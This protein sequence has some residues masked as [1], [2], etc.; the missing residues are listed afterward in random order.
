MI[1]K[2]LDGKVN[3]DSSKFFTEQGS[4][5][6]Q[7]SAKE[8]EQDM[9]KELEDDDIDD[10]V[11]DAIDNPDEDSDTGSTGIGDNSNDS[12]DEDGNGK[13][14]DD[15]N[16]NNNDS[17]D[18]EGSNENDDSNGNEGNDVNKNDNSD[19]EGDEATNSDDNDA[20]ADDDGEDELQELTQN[21]L[22]KLL[23]AID[24][25]KDFTDGNI[26]KESIESG[27]ESQVEALETA[28]IT[29]K[30]VCDDAH[31]KDVIVIKNLT[32]S[33]IDNDPFDIFEKNG[34]SRETIQSGITLGTML[35]RKLQIRNEERTTQFTRLK[36]GKID[37]RLINSLGYGAEQVFS[38]LT[39][40]KFNPVKLH[41]SID[42]S[43]SMHGSKWNKT[44]IAAIAICKAASMT[45]NLDVVLDIRKTDNSDEK[46]LVIIVY[47]SRRDKFEKI[48]RVMP[49][50]CAGG[51]TPEGLCFEAI[52]DLV[53]EN[54][55]VDQYFINFSDGE[56]YMSNYGGEFAR[57]HTRQ[58]VQ[59]MRDKGINIMSFYINDS[60]YNNNEP[61]AAFKLMYG[62][63]ARAI[64]V[65]E[66]IPLAKSI[67]SL[68]AEK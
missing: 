68:F 1:I 35:G 19:G 9:T 62:K 33:F 36:N 39:I 52:G 65:N 18:D 27:K 53:K 43:G 30:S 59:K 47:D 31:K 13:D 48:N 37:R 6:Q 34:T 64:N 8:P 42:A 66:L 16:D 11:E 49:F 60:S 41:I 23:R 12:D 17:E 51:L 26:E 50:I 56:P 38:Q 14:A 61:S 29:I 67:N 4:D 55:S 10:N 40:D 2:T 58:Q 21:Q 28:D 44:M 45:N 63:D 7:S 20:E 54:K 46:P 24:K 15:T 5:E 25:Q 57:T 3:I 32:Q 22:A